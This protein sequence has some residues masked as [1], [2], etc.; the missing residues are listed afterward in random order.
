MTPAAPVLI[1]DTTSSPRHAFP[2]N[3]LIWVGPAHPVRLVYDTPAKARPHHG[4]HAV[5]T[6]WEADEDL[7]G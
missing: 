1:K 6:L 4:A 7:I 2:A 5:R 3:R